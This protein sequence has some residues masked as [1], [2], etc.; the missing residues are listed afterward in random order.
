MASSP[1]ERMWLQRGPLPPKADFFFGDRAPFFLKKKGASTV[2]Q[3]EPSYPIPA[4][5]VFVFCFGFMGC[6][7]FASVFTSGCE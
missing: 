5:L 4:M 2:Q 3:D 1:K 7:F 6:S